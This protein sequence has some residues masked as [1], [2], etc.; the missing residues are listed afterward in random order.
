MIHSSLNG[1]EEITS[2]S[3]D[4]NAKLT[5]RNFTAQFLVIASKR[6]SGYIKTND[7]KFY[8]NEYKF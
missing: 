3:A 4:E 6:F 2:L 1:T 8:V 7:F 5:F